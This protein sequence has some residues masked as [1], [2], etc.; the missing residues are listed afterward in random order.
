[1]HMLEMSLPDREQL[2]LG[3]VLIKNDCQKE[4]RSLVPLA[5]ARVLLWKTE[6]TS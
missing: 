5:V 4:K 6:G 1:M 3:L 2:S